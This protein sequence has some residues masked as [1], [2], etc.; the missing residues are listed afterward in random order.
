VV[1]TLAVL[2]ALLAGHSLLGSPLR[3][4]IG[5]ASPGVDRSDGGR[6]VNGLPIY[7]TWR[8]DEMDRTHGVDWGDWD[9]DGDLDLAVANDSAEPNRVYENTGGSLTLAW[10]SLEMNSTR[11]SVAP[12]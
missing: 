1:A 5:G 7:F 6:A 11:Y 4:N 9:G 8:S 2:V 3:R 12:R 10:T